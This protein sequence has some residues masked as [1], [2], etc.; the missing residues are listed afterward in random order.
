MLKRF[1]AR[2]GSWI[3]VP[4]KV[5]ALFIFEISFSE[6]KIVVN[7]ASSVN[8]HVVFAMRHLAIFI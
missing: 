1:F 5:S 6:M 7:Y 4:L 3:F 8:F 2:G